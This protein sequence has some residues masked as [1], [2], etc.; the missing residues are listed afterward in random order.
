[1]ILYG[2]PIDQKSIL[3]SYLKNFCYIWQSRNVIIF[4]HLHVNYV[5]NFVK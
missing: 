1:M 4:N 3:K 2:G 5:L